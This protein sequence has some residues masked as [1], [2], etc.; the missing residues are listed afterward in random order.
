MLDFTCAVFSQS[1]K[2]H[3]PRTGC[4]IGN[5][6]L[7]SKTM[8]LLYVLLFSTKNTKTTKIK[9]YHPWKKFETI[10]KSLQYH[11]IG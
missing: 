9:S 8:Q 2:E 11:Y 4:N 7:S 10:K 5:V 6:V 1:E 3:T